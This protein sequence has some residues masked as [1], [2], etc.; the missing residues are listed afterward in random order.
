MVAAKDLSF[1]TSIN[2]EVN[3]ALRALDAG[4]IA[5]SEPVVGL[6]SALASYSEE[7]DNLTPTVFIFKSAAEMVQRAGYG[8]YIYLGTSDISSSVSAEILKRA[9]P[10]AKSQ[11]RIFVEWS[12][13]TR[14]RYGII[15]GS[16]DPAALTIEDA[17][18]DS[19]DATFPVVMIRQTSRNK[20]SF[21]TT[22]GAEINFLFNA[23][24]DQ[25]QTNTSQHVQKLASAICSGVESGRDSFSIYIRNVLESSLRK[26][27]GSLIV[28]VDEDRHDLKGRLNE[29]V[30]TDP[31]LDLATRFHEHEAAPSAI[32]L[33][34]LQAASDV[35]GGFINSDGVTIFSTKGSVLGFRCLV[36][37][38]GIAG[39]KHGGA[40]T[41][42]FLALK[43]AIGTE[44]CAAY[45]QSQDGRTDFASEG[46]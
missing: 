29:R 37:T 38:T 45:F 3:D 4:F 42:A 25:P 23:D 21:K 44:M 1:R 20:V 24:Q 9:A 40:R 19:S 15:S 28:V 36:D 8:E 43:A 6:I 11:W 46:E 7:G 22:S 18:F 12:S 31:A 32:T 41:K 10:L 17:S 5:V 13:G 2:S 14:C 16:A 35:V 26:C 30:P 34:K 39:A 33:G 27:H